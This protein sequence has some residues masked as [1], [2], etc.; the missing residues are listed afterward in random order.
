MSNFVLRFFLRSVYNIRCD[1]LA[2]KGSHFQNCFNMSVSILK[3]YLISGAIYFCDIG[4]AE[5]FRE[6]KLA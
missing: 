1:F 5:I 3:T 6:N 4:E 2:S